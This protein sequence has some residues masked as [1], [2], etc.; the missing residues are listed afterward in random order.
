M[1]GTMSNKEKLSGFDADQSGGEFER[2]WRDNPLP[3]V[4]SRPTEPWRR[5]LHG[6]RGGIKTLNPPVQDAMPGRKVSRGPYKRRAA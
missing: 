4:R 1:G 5:Q 6:Y 3:S 2:D